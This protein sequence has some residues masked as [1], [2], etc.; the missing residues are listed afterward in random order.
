MAQYSN[1]SKSLW[2]ETDTLLVL[3]LLFPLGIGLYGVSKEV[4]QI[5]QPS[6]ELRSKW[7]C[8]F[9]PPVKLSLQQS[10]DIIAQ[11]SSL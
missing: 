6:T 3:F 5:K 4:S 8:G 11:G 9:L 10:R 7:G 2:V 1:I